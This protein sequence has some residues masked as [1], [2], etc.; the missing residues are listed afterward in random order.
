MNEIQSAVRNL[1]ITYDYKKNELDRR[2]LEVLRQQIF[3]SGNQCEVDKFLAEY[4]IRYSCKNNLNY[5]IA[6]MMI[7]DH[8]LTIR[9]M[10]PLFYLSYSCVFLEKVVMLDLPSIKNVNKESYEN[11]KKNGRIII[12][13]WVKELTGK[14]PKLEAIIDVLE[15]YDKKKKLEQ[16]EEDKKEY[17]IF[18]RRC[19]L[20]EKHYNEIHGKMI[21]VF[22]V[23]NDLMEKLI[24][25]ELKNMLEK[26]NSLSKNNDITSNINLAKAHGYDI[27][28]K[29]EVFLKKDCFKIDITDENREIFT[30]LKKEYK[31]CC[32][33]AKSLTRKVDRLNGSKNKYE[34]QLTDK[35]SMLREK[36]RRYIQK[37]NDLGIDRFTV[38]EEDLGNKEES[39]DSDFED[40]D[41]DTL[42]DAP[43]KK[44]KKVEEGESIKGNITK[45]GHIDTLKYNPNI[46]YDVDSNNVNVK[47]KTSGDVNKRLYVCFYV[48]L[49]FY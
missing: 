31:V 8:F 10:F 16:D 21:N 24:P 26:D 11:M 5:R 32:S 42:D 13:K 44:I 22:K 38:D 27:N 18:M 15:E 29:I 20:A 45:A 34:I 1:I 37:C 12:D 19:E 23:M 35:C 39:D 46:K 2:N 9:Q 40:I 49:M 47:V 4:L 28:T 41:M 30:E 36:I 7:A 14:Y 6:T 43:L 48:S 33:V 3:N 17:S 25:N